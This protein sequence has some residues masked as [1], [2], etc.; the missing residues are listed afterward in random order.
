MSNFAF[1][2]IITK[3]MRDLSTVSFCASHSAAT[4]IDSKTL[5]FCVNESE[6]ADVTLPAIAR[7]S[8]FNMN[9]EPDGVFSLRLSS[10]TSNLPSQHIT[11]VFL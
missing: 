11:L 10:V 5:Y 8:L 4:A 7:G 9:G 1:M 6:L 3:C 2:L